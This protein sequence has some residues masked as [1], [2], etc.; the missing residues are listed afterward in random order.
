MGNSEQNRA[1][2]YS[3][4]VDL[5]QLEPTLTHLKIYKDQIINGFKSVCEKFQE[6]APHHEK[7]ILR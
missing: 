3:I 4:R 2:K 5:D 1:Q 7:I 6:D